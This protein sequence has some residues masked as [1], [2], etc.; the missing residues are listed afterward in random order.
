MDESLKPSN[1]ITGKFWKPT[2]VANTAIQVGESVVKNLQ[3]S[4]IV[5]DHTKLETLPQS[6]REFFNV[7]RKMRVVEL[8]IPANELNSSTANLICRDTQWEIS[9]IS[10]I[11]FISVLRNSKEFD[12]WEWVGLENILEA[13]FNQSKKEFYSLYF[14]PVDFFKKT[15]TIPDFALMEYSFDPIYLEWE[16]FYTI[17]TTWDDNLQNIGISPEA[18]LGTDFREPDFL[19]M[20]AHY[21]E[22]VYRDPIEDYTND[23]QIAI[24]KYDYITGITGTGIVTLWQLVGYCTTEIRDRNPLIQ[25]KYIIDIVRNY[26]D[27]LAPSTI[28][29]KIVPLK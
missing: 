19:L 24:A 18:I 4:G 1:V 23:T 15:E 11:E 5:I 28:E 26:I 6:S 10:L 16:Y 17:Q 22:Q 2:W 8:H 12:G 3:I 7:L 27:R 20:V 9:R 25:G 21:L 13:L 14:S 29:A